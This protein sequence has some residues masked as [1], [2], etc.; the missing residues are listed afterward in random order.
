V[1][2]RLLV[3]A[4]VVLVGAVATASFLLER[5][6]RSWLER[7][8]GQELARQA[9]VAREVVE[10]TASRGADDLDALADR[11]GRAVGVRVT[12]FD[13]RGVVVGDS[14]LDRE[15]VASAAEPDETEQVRRALSGGVAHARTRGTGTRGRELSLALP[16]RAPTGTGALR[17]ATPVGEIDRA[18]SRVR[19]VLL[20]AALASVLVAVV[21]AG[22]GSYRMSRALREL[23]GSAR[24]L[25]SGDRPLAGPAGRDELGRL[26]GSIHH[27]SAELE[28]TV[29]ELAGER[30]LLETVLG[31]MGDAVLAVDGEARIR[32]ANP[33]A[34]RLLRIEGPPAGRLLLEVV[35]LP[36]LKDILS[37]ATH[38]AET[39]TAELELPRIPPR[40]VLVRVAPLREPSGHVVV[41]QDV[42][43]M[44]QLETVR[45]DFVANVSHELRTPVSVI[46]GSAETLLD[47]AM[48]PASARRFLEAVH[49]NAERLSR[50]ISDLLDLS[51][52]EA[53]RYA[54]EL[55]PVPLRAALGRAADA[56]AEPA[57]QKG[58]S[59][60]IGGEA[61]LAVVADPQALDHVLMNLLDNAVKYTPPGGHIRLAARREAGAVRAEVTDDGPGIEPRHQERVFERFYRVDPGRSR[62]MGG[63][64]LGLSIVKH[65]VES[66]GGAVGLETVSPHGS[67]FWFTLPAVEGQAHAPPARSAGSLS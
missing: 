17:L 42:T 50:L 32:L 52:I 64:G 22:L 18:V 2:S 38:E 39:V 24:A 6:T 36:A 47:G 7:R 49:G 30:D 5:R 58:H 8:T 51:R 1:R 61:E 40:R 3:L 57:R 11:L 26:A 14:V 16:Y 43:E 4:L 15:Q 41:M 33:A 34:V 35:R 12:I 46:L 28:R 37:H 9:E 20:S 55:R 13:P 66:M 19:A 53:G 60:E 31:S 44:R 65:L 67:R 62:E 54:M 27:M 48:D 21:A 29:G 10:D 45:R 59:I 63:T 23:V 56:V 25:A